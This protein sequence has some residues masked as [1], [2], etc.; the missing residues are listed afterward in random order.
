MIA[1]TKIAR[2]YARKTPYDKEDLIQEA[3]SAGGEHGLRAPVRS[4]SWAE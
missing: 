2:L 3:L 1:L 4:C